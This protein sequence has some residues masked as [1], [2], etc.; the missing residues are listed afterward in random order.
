MCILLVWLCSNFWGRPLL[1]SALAKLGSFCFAFPAL[2]AFP[3][4]PLV[5]LKAR[6]PRRR[7]S[8]FCS[9]EQRALFQQ[10]RPLVGTTIERP[11]E[12]LL[13]LDGRPRPSR[14]RF[15]LRSKPNSSVFTLVAGTANQR[16]REEKGA[17]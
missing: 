12:N 4:L 11:G 13:G 10:Q 14:G 3:V 9:N 2:S 15:S 6:G 5:K 16:Q 8:C 7:F 17:S 1:L